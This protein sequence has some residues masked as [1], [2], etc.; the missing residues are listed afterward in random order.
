M[1]GLPSKLFSDFTSLKKK[2]AGLKTVV[3]LGGWTFND[4]GEFHP[5]QYPLAGLGHFI[6]FAARAGSKCSAEYQTRIAQR[7]DTAPAPKGP[8]S[9]SVD[10]ADIRRRPNTESFQRDGQHQGESRQIYPKPLF[11]L[12]AI[13]L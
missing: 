5:L 3:A 10:H 9:K 2:N 11:F 6:L 8:D 13:C 7:L 4:P 12:A 1:D